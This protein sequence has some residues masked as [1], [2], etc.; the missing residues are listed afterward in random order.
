ML[1]VTQPDSE[2]FEAGGWAPG[3]FYLGGDNAEAAN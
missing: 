3:N 2:Q 1:P